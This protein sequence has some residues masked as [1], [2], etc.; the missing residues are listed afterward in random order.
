MD[1]SQ[2]FPGVPRNLL[3]DGVFVWIHLL[4]LQAVGTAS[5][6]VRS[7]P[8]PRLLDSI[9]FTVSTNT[10]PDGSESV[11]KSVQNSKSDFLS[12]YKTM[13]YKRV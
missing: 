5:A 13:T 2:G 12:A 8:S 1:L 3:G 11:Q 9:N 4:L 10:L 6:A 7:L